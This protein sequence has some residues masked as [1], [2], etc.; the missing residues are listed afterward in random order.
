M[1][2]LSTIFQN[3]YF[4]FKFVSRHGV[5][6]FTIFTHL[7]WQER[8][9][10]YRLAKE[11]EA[12]FRLVEIGSYLGGSGYFLAAA[13]SEDA[14][15]SVLYCIDTWKNDGMS[16]GRRDTWKEFTANTHRFSANII[17]L[18][19]LSIDIGK[20]FSGEIDLLFIDGDHSYD[21][22]R[23]DV[24]TWLPKVKRGGTVLFHDYGWA[25]GVRKVVFDLTLRSILTSGTAYQNIYWAYKA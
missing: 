15:E 23:G 8:V 21:G 24:E 20:S 18:R 3:L 14:I 5:Y 19:G 6:G 17:P 12:P 7:T 13:A 10:L 16:E 11:I 4:T 2:S 1:G 9:I 22:C 25:E